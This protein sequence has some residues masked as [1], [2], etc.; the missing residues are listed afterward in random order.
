MV[1]IDHTWQPW[2]ASYYFKE[3]EKTFL[4]DDI[5]NNGQV[6]KA[7]IQRLPFSSALLQQLPHHEN[8]INSG[9]PCSKATLCF[10]E[11]CTASFRSLVNTASTKYSPSYIAMKF[12][13]KCCSRCNIFCSCKGLC[14]NHLCLGVL[15]RTGRVRVCD[16]QRT[17]FTIYAGMPQLPE[18]T[19][20]CRDLSLWVSHPTP[21]SKKGW[22]CNYGS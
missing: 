10:W 8:H 16:G 1:A 17:V 15:P 20:L 7:N 11:T 3:L 12:Q 22:V 2:W 6:N 14:L 5:K 21:P 18:K 19:W 9:T 13:Y 4:A